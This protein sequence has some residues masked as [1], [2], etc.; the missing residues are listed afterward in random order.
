MKIEEN[1]KR[2]KIISKKNEMKIERKTKKEANE[3]EKTEWK[4]KVRPK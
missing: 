1:A 2:A 4:L 3:Q